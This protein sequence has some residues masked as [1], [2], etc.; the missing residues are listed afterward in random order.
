V[1][2][3]HESEVD[4]TVVAR[5]KLKELMVR[6]PGS[7]DVH[8]H[9]VA[10][11]WRFVVD[12]AV[13]GGDLRR[14][15]H[16]QEF[17]GSLYNL[18]APGDTV[19]VSYKEDHPD[20]L[21]FVLEKS[22]YD[23]NYMSKKRDAEQ[24]ARDAEAVLLALERP[25]GSAPEAR[26]RAQD[27]QTAAMARTDDGTQRPKPA[28]PKMSPQDK[29]RMEKLRLAR[30]GSPGTAVILAL[31][32]DG[33]RTA[34]IRVQP[35]SGDEFETT[36]EVLKG[37]LEVGQSVRVRFNPAHRSKVVLLNTASA[38]GL[39]RVP[40]H[41]PDCGAPVDQAVAAVAAHPVCPYCQHSLP[42]D[43]A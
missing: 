19:T 23:V 34:T 27:D 35:D 28:R 36:I 22:Q 33:T 37:H 2:F 7:G 43:P 21:N 38:D 13:D 26:A 12:V 30:D 18:P 20:N 31:G 17:R 6:A 24:K 39:W 4:A 1:V 29:L 15:L 3:G 14:V 25:P 8:T 32:H 42:R 41:C 5:E 11:T 9:Q 40:T 10:E 16:D